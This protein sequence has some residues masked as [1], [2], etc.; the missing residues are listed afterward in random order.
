MERSMID[1]NKEEF[2]KRFKIYKE[3][4]TTDVTPPDCKDCNEVATIYDTL[5]GDNYC[6]KC[7]RKSLMADDEIIE[8]TEEYMS[9]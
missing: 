3:K 7:L 6:E 2:E 9:N 8:H 1:I 4:H 5:A